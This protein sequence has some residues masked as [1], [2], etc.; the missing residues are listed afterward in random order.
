MRVLLTGATG[1]VGR[2]VLDRLVI[3]DDMEPVAAIRSHALP[4]IARNVKTVGISGL[5]ADTDWS[6][7]LD[8]VEAVI[9]SAARVHVMNDTETDPL[10]AFRKVNVEGTLKLARQASSMGVRRFV[11]IS[12]IKVNGEGTSI[13][14]PYTADALPAPV[15]PYGFSKMEA[16]QGLREIAAQSGM[17][18]VIIRPTLVYGP[19]V[20]ANFLNMMRWLHKGIPLP[21]GA[22]H[23]RRSLV[24][25]D[26]LV[27]LIVTC[28]HHPAAANQTFLVSDGEDLSTTQ[29]LQ[30][31]GIALGKPAR[32]LPV[33]SKLLEKSAQLLGKRA[34]SQ[35]LCG[36]LQVD[37]TKTRELLDWNPPVDV[38]KALLLTANYFLSKGRKR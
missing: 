23:N 17:E 14:E 31:I 30:R 9:H 33:P 21:F 1:F 20:K 7:A 38:D 22:I 25:L 28:I 10:E 12:S 18:V 2:A 11:F 13:N 6:E 15:D 34:L 37:I 8:Q 29:L 32:L 3:S 24:A 19:G 5:L 27:D 35:R 26:N 36:S 4:D 16:E